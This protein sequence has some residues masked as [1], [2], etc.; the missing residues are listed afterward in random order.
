MK[1]FLLYVAIVLLLT[2][3]MAAAADESWLNIGADYRFRYDILAG[4]MH[5]HVGLDQTGALVAVPAANI[6]ND[7]VWL[8]RLGLDLKADATED[9][10][11]K[12]RLM[13]YKSGGHQTMQ[14]VQDSFFADRAAG[15]FDGTIG[16]VPSSGTLKVDQAY[17]TLGNIGGMPFWVSAGRRPSTG[18]V[19]TNIRQNL[20]KEGT[21]GVPGNMIDYAFDGASAGYAP[22]ID[23]LPGSYAK[24]CYGKGY[25][26]GFTSTANT[27]KD[28]DFLGLN[29]VP[30]D[31]D[32]L[33]IDL[34][35]QKGYHLTDRPSVYPGPPN[36]NQQPINPDN[37]P[38][39]PSDNVGNIGWWGGVVTGKVSGFNLFASLAQSK[40][41]PTLHNVG[42][43]GLLWDTFHQGTNKKHVGTSIYVGARYDIEST[44]TKIGAEYNQGSQYWV[45]MV[46]AADDLWTSKL[47]TRGTVYEFYVIQEL[48]NEPLMELAKSFFRL[49]Y[50]YYEFDY[51]GSNNWMG[52]PVKISELNQTNPLNVQFL[53]PLENASD[54]YLTWDVLF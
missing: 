47:G 38:I 21:A 41:E 40:T 15:P 33:H 8:D 20:E 5:E 14:P 6:K 10:A 36:T 37:P 29:V 51:T 2:A 53:K 35:V 46:P 16:H 22:D 9:L 48:N 3:G 44:G 45:G 23:M 49:G 17:A 7:S 32:K 24:L 54:I 11:V 27:L 19:P 26:S 30:Y 34:Q 43:Y 13:M 39:P 18:G 52:A 28:T 25:D 50:Q 12:I 31:S 1:K 42:G 4:D